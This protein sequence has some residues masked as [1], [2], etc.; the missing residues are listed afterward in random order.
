MR[1]N[2]ATDKAR[3]IDAIAAECAA[4]IKPEPLKPTTFCSLLQNYLQSLE[5]GCP[6]SVHYHNFLEVS[7][8]ME[9]SQAMGNLAEYRRQRAMLLAGLY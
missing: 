4:A 6:E 8:A 7:A 1:Y 5:V 2:P 3:S 9:V